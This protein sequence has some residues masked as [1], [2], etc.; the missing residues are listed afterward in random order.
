MAQLFANAARGV[1]TVAVT[2]ADTNLVL[3]LS[4]TALFPTATMGT[5]TTGSWF[6][7]VIQDASKYEVVYVRSS[8]PA[9]DTLSN[10]LRGQEGTT[11][12]AFDVGAVVGLRP[13]ASDMDAAINDRLP[14]N[15]ASLTEA[16]ALAGTENTYVHDGTGVKRLTLT[17]L[18]GW[19]LGKVN[20]WTARQV[21]SVV[22]FTGQFANGNS[23]TAKL[24][25]WSN[26]QK[27]SL[28]LNNNCTITQTF[29]GP[30]N[31][32]LILL[33]DTT[34]NRTVT[35]SGVS[36]WVGSA[37]QPA[38]NTAANSATVVS[39][40]YDGANVYLAASKVNA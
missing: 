27:Q 36:R 14:S 38:I 28:V 3:S 25:D 1:L 34:G 33:Q 32:Q 15:P 17:G 37:T 11:A 40:Y 24:I 29:P 26:G 22:S 10:V 5:G 21:F 39:L 30:G 19:L 13:L 8:N 7:A 31:Y 20:N 4:D 6:K 2:A 23:G 9:S 12:S 18:V 35:W 16:A